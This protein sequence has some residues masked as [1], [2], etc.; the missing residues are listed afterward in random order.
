MASFKKNTKKILYWEVMF[1]ERINSNLIC[2][3]ATILYSQELGFGQGK[4]IKNNHVSKVFYTPVSLG[5]WSLHQTKWYFNSSI[6]KH[7]KLWCGEYEI[8][9][10]DHLSAKFYSNHTSTMS[11]KFSKS[12]KFLFFYEG[13][14]LKKYINSQRIIKFI[15]LILLKNII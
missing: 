9:D 4:M 6:K 2:N 7:L 3:W 10:S 12:S 1:Q 8:L 11:I 5:H 13:I 15:Y 14:K